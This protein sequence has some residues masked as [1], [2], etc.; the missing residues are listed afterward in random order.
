MAS[1]IDQLYLADADLLIDARAV[2]LGG[3]R[4]LNRTTNGYS[5]LMLLRLASGVSQR[6]RRT[7][8]W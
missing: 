4:G 1:G 3:Q 8:D 2:F 6:V 5:L 7:E